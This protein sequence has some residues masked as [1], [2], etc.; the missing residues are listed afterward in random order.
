[1]RKT[2][3]LIFGYDLCFSCTE[4]VTYIVCCNCL[5]DAGLVNNWKCGLL[6]VCVGYGSLPAVIGL[7]SITCIF[8]LLGTKLS[9]PIRLDE[10]WYL[11]IRSWKRCRHIHYVYLVSLQS[12]QPPGYPLPIFYT[13]LSLLSGRE[14][15]YKTDRN[16]WTFVDIL[17]QHYVGIGMTRY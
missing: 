6:R 1:M 2:Y 9:Y 12:L 10:G 8:V 13:P 4:S 17:L 5:S 11:V 14:S 7:L 3:Y 16:P 15:V